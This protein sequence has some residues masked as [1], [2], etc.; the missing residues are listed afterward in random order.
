MSAWGMNNQPPDNQN[1][2]QHVQLTLFFKDLLPSIWATP[3]I[4]N[5]ELS[6]FKHQ[7]SPL[8]FKGVVVIIFLKTTTMTKLIVL[9]FHRALVQAPSRASLYRCI[10]YGPKT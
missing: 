7:Q 6:A 3:N 5:A 1:H 2:S 9:A 4:L 8:S 10:Y